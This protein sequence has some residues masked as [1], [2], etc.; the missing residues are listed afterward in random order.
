M[1]LALVYCGDRPLGKRTIRIPGPACTGLIRE[2]V[3][4]YLSFCPII[5]APS[6]ILDLSCVHDST[7]R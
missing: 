4:G 5:L 7:G 1:D 2:L 6:F 3:S